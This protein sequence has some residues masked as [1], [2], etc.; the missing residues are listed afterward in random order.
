MEA[1]QAQDAQIVF[2]DARRGIAD[3]AHAAGLQIVD[4]ADGV[5]DLA[6]GGRVERVH[7]EVAALRVFRPV[8]GEGDDGAAAVGRDVAA[9]GRDLERLA[10]R[11]SP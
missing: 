3:E 4:A 5:E 10:V 6:V 9:Q 11:R 7:G 8:G 2:A 1:E